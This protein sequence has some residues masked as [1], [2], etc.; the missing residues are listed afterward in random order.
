MADKPTQSIFPIE[1]GK[2]LTALD[3]NNFPIHNLDVANSE[4][5]GT[6]GGGSGND[7]GT[8]TAILKGD[9]DHGFADAVAGVDYA[10]AASVSGKED[11]TSHDSDIA[12]LQGFITTLNNEV[13]VN[14]ADILLKADDAATTASLALKLDVNTFESYQASNDSA[15]ALK[16]DEA[17]LTALE[18]V[19]AL[20][21]LDSDLQAYITSNDIAV[22][23]KAATTY[24]DAADALKADDADLVSGLALKEDL[25]PTTASNNFVLVR[26]ADDTWRFVDPVTLGSTNASYTDGVTNS[27]L[28]F[29]SATALF[30]NAD[31]GKTIVATGDIPAATTIATVVNPANITLSQAATSTATGVA[32]TI[33]NRYIPGATGG[34]V[35]SV[36]ISTSG[37]ISG[38]LSSS[39][40]NP[41]TTPII[42][43]GLANASAN[44]FFG[45]FT[46][47]TT[48]PAHGTAAQARTSLGGTTVGQAL[49]Q[50]TNPSA[51]SYARINADNTITTRTTAQTLTDLGAENALTF[52]TPL[53]RSTNTISILQASNTIPGFLSAADWN[54]FNSKLSSSVTISTTAPLTGGGDLSSNRTFS[55][56]AATTALSGHLT[57]TDWNTFNSKLASTRTI[58]TTAPLTGGGNLTADRTIAI[59]PASA[60]VDGYLTFG[61][62]N[63]F[64]AKPPNSRTIATTA[65]LAGGGD[66]SANRTISMLSATANRDGYL[67]SADFIAFNS[68]SPRTQP[69]T[70]SNG[71]VTIASSTPPIT[72]VVLTLTLTG[73]LTLNLPLPNLYTS[74]NGYPFIEIVDVAN[75]PAMTSFGVTLVTSGGSFID[76]VQNGS[77][78]MSRASTYLRLN[79]DSGARWTSTKYFV[80]SFRDSTVPSKAVRVDVS[81]QTAGL[82]GSLVLGGGTLV[83]GV[84]TSVTVNPTRTAGQG[85][86]IPGVLLDIYDDGSTS[87]GQLGP[88]DLKPVEHVIGTTGVVIPDSIVTVNQAGGIDTVRIAGTLVGPLTV[89]WPPAGVYDSGDTVKLIDASGSVSISRPVTVTHAGVNSN[90]FNGA[91]SFVFDE[92]NGTKLLVADGSSSPGNWTVSLVKTSIQPYVVVSPNGSTFTISGNTSAVQHN[93]HINLLSGA[94][95]LSCP[96]AYDGMQL[97]LVLQQP[98]SGAAGTLNL[99]IGSRVQGGALGVVSL[100]ATN[101]AVDR[102]TGQYDGFLSAFLWQTPL[103]NYTSAVVPNAPSALATSGITSSKVV[104]TWTDNSNNETGFAV[105]RAPG[106]S[107]TNFAEIVGNLP[108]NTLT[109]TDTGVQPATGY[110]YRVNAFNSAG[111]SANSATA[112]A[113][114]SAGGQTADVFEVHFNENATTSASTVVPGGGLN[115]TLNYATDWTTSTESGS[116]AALNV[117]PGMTALSSSNLTVVN[118]GTG[119]GT[120]SYSYKVCAFKTVNGL[121]NAFTGAATTITTGVANLSASSYNAL[122]W[123]AVTGANY[124]EV[125][126][127]ASG[128]SGQ[129]AQIG[130]LNTGSQ[131]VTNSLNDTGFPQNGTTPATITTATDEHSAF[132]AP[133]TVSYLTSNKLTV[134]FWIKGVFTTTGTVNIV[135]AG[136][137]ASG[138]RINY[139]AASKFQIVYPGSTGSATFTVPNTTVADNGWHHVAITI[140]NS[141]TTATIADVKAYY[142]GSVTAQ[143]T[144]AGTNTKSG[145]LAW[146]NSSPKVGDPT[147]TYVIDDVR[148]YSTILGSSAI[149]TLYTGHAQ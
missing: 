141:T 15:V 1:N 89:V 11:A 60:S 122:S 59:P 145:A 43:L 12:T 127:T 63:T 42:A 119:S 84:P 130:R 36:G 93:A 48:A 78:A 131:I 115:M 33:L 64:T 116:G 73:N 20:Q 14:T 46:G 144:S 100:T 17:D 118:G 142:D 133:N 9:G 65:P 83:G 82:I 132:F 62:F 66:L 110:N 108:A 31:V 90:T 125:Y 5:I 129:G 87:K 134:A 30:T 101:G 35:T 53:A 107:G 102:L 54:T 34:T 147:G 47:S 109:Y 16:A 92:P 96:N 104:L 40:S 105:E 148:I 106:T 120:T 124:Y 117:T 80:D 67:T 51:V 94:N 91:N 24:V 45:N 27:D 81:K 21:A 49:F 121:R 23:L 88:I 97:D 19:V 7:T 18:G 4:G 146:P 113:T 50:L 32:F 28:T 95:T 74:T 8:T 26:D 13:A 61:D 2:L 143:T 112:S 140:D 39:V 68:G 56:P 114:T 149:T 103:L 57:S 99:P 138:W 70:V 128:G 98:S 76:G 72:R 44:T 29:S 41:T 139:I 136:L 25:L 6:G 123:T 58:T 71:T 38:L 135:S 22:G 69:I 79:S 111:H 52:S 3:A 75:P 85:Q 55:I 126:R 10:T 86:T 77:L 137:G 37:S